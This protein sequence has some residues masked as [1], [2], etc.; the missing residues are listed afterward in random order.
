VD[1]DCCVESVVDE[2][3]GWTWLAGEGGGELSWEGVEAG[4]LAAGGGV[5]L[6][7]GV[8]AFAPV[9]GSST[10]NVFRMILSPCA[11]RH[12][13]LPYLPGKSHVKE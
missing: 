1:V 7:A 8:V 11:N 5:A 6:G 9:S 3:A 2:V 10:Q 13:G 4:G 12:I